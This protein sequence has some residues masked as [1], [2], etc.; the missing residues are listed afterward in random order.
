MNTMRVPKYCAEMRPR[1]SSDQLGLDD[2]TQ[3][4]ILHAS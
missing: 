4:L 1:A 3:V 2:A